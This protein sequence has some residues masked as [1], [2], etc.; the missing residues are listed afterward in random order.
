MRKP[1]WEVRSQQRGGG[2]GGGQ[3][4]GRS[5][6][7]PG[8][9]TGEVV[10]QLRGHKGKR[11]HD[12]WSFRLNTLPYRQVRTDPSTAPNLVQ[13]SEGRG[14]VPYCTAASG[15]DN[16]SALRQLPHSQKGLTIPVG[17]LHRWVRVS[18][19][20]LHRAQRLCRNAEVRLGWSSACPHWGQ[21]PTTFWLGSFHKSFLFS[22]PQFP[23]L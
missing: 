14:G 10:W 2:E 1:G 13:T 16:L 11:D 4:N 23:L 17:S 7:E 5:V 6:E 20:P 8:F 21:D 15:L 12:L 19:G 3:W 22:V 18:R 9:Y